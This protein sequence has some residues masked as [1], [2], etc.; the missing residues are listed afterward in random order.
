MSTV[1]VREYLAKAEEYAVAATN[2]LE[3]ERGIAATSFAIY[4]GISAADAVCGARLGRRAAGQHHD[5][6]LNLLRQAGEDGGELETHLRGS[7][8]ARR[9]PNTSPTTSHGRPPPRQSSALRSLAIVRRVVA[10]RP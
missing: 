1:Q 10:A 2:E 3:A 9:R 8:R 5:E 6:V 7:Y 4:A